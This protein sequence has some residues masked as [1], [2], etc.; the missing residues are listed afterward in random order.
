[1]HWTKLYISHGIAV[2]AVLQF[3]GC[4]CV[5]QV[6]SSRLRALVLPGHG[7]LQDKAQDSIS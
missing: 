3:G 2:I 5:L 4:F 7:E 1:M 6:P